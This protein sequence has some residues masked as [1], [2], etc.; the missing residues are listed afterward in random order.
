M[1]KDHIQEV[2]NGF[3]FTAE[4]PKGSDQ[5]VEIK[6]FMR[7]QSTPPNTEFSIV[8]E[9]DKEAR[10][11]IVLT[12]QSP[13]SFS[14]SIPSLNVSGFIDAED[15]IFKPVCLLLGVFFSDIRLISVL[16]SGIAL[17]ME[18]YAPNPIRPLQPS[19]HTIHPI[20]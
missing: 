6:G 3:L 12:E 15:G 8:P 20:W 9:F 5:I 10:Y 7:I 18:N 17:Y 1:N 2:N 11:N 13:G 19:I 4:V 14:L 16:A